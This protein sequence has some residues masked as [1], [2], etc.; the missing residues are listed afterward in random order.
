MHLLLKKHAV[1]QKTGK[2]QGMCNASR[3]TYNSFCKCGIEG[4]DV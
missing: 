3:T 2:F 4:I 1:E